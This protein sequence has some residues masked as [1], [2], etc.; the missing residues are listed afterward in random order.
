MGVAAL[1][2]GGWKTGDSLFAGEDVHSCTVRIVG[3]GRIGSVLAQRLT[4]FD[5]TILY[6]G[7]K[8]KPEVAKAVDAEF[9]TLDNLL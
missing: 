4:G 6:T 1:R 3:L 7:H 8:P 9:F 5:C 2:A